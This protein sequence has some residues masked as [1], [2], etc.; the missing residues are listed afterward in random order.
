[1]P[2]RMAPNIPR[3]LFTLFLVLLLLLSASGF[4]IDITKREETDPLLQV[5]TRGDHV[6]EL[7]SLL[8][9]LNRD[10]RTSG[11]VRVHEE[12][13]RPTYK[14]LWGKSDVLMVHPVA[15]DQPGVV[16][17]SEVT[18]T[19]RG[20]L[21]VSISKHPWGDH[22]VKIRKN[23]GEA[24][25]QHIAR[26]DWET[27]RVDFDKEDVLIEIHATGWKWENSFLT[28]RIEKR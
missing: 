16:D 7:H 13:G 15:P 18:K 19:S 26:N 23:G 8:D 21:N 11:T 22:L 14:R 6:S 17:F 20:R 25:S 5:Q 10:H 1:M 9:L 4:A 28:Y 24:V 12:T 3:Q 27:L 2:F